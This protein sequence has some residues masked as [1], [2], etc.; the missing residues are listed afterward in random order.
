MPHLAR[1]GAEIY[2]EISGDGPAVLL[3][4]SL[5]CDGR[6]W[7]GVVPALAEQYRVINVDFRGHRH[8]TAPGPFT[9]DDLAA[10]WLAILDELAIERAVLCGLSMGG[11]TAFCFSLK[12]PERVAG[13]IGIDTNG[14]AEILSNRIKYTAMAAIYARF[15]LVDALQRTTN[16]LMFGRTTLAE[17]PEL[18]ELLQERVAGHDRAQLTRAIRAVFTR[19]SFLPELHQLQCPVLLLIGEEDMATPLKW[20]QRLRRAIPGSMLRL[21]PRAGHLSAMEQ[22][23]TVA[24]LALDFLPSCA[25]ETATGDARRSSAR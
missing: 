5:L 20:S 10:D 19:R 4:H 16:K 6:M 2:Y 25:W 17:R 21:I 12:H 22:P 11:M 1:N 24:E 13:I 23:D 3:G 15:G 14:D 9:F 8:S 18:V 7:E